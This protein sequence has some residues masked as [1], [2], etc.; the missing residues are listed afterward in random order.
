[1]KF[2][3]ANKVYNPQVTLAA[4]LGFRIWQPLP[5]FT[6]WFC[7]DILWNKVQLCLQIG[8]TVILHS[9]SWFLCKDNF[10]DFFF[11]FF[12]I[13]HVIFMPKHTAL[14]LHTTTSAV[15]LQ[16]NCRHNSK[17]KFNVVS[18]CRNHTD[19]CQKSVG[20]VQMRMAMW[21]L[22]HLQCI[23]IILSLST[24]RL[25]VCA[26]SWPFILHAL[27]A[28]WLN[29]LSYMVYFRPWKKIH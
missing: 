6:S 1:M 15:G 4:S 19:H 11:F 28:F 5:M 2:W 21:N 27:G 3:W 12:L 22:V 29:F 23:E 18:T 16:L 14:K 20:H 13:F 26:R 8:Y 24:Q 25:F 9:L 7:H 10:L 17:L